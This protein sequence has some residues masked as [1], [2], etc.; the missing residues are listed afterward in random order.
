MRILTAKT[1]KRLL[2]E[3]RKEA[4]EAGLHRGYRLGYKMGQ[5]AQINVRVVGAQYPTMSGEA[6]EIF[7]KG[8]TMT[9]PPYPERDVPESVRKDFGEHL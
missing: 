5:I 2:D 1:L 7:D 3:A 4:D 8:F 6:D 9:Y